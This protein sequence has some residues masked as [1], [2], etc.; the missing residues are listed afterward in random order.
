MPMTNAA[1]T[2]VDRRE[3]VAGLIRAIT[4]PDQ[5][6]GVRIPTYPSLLTTG[7]TQYRGF[8]EW[9][10]QLPGNVFWGLMLR[11][12]MFPLWLSQSFP[13]NAGTIPW[14]YT[15]VWGVDG[16]VPAVSNL[17]V[18]V[19]ASVFGLENTYAGNVA[20]TNTF[21]GIAGTSIPS[22]LS[23]NL[24]IAPLA[25][26]RD[27]DKD[28]SPFI[29]VPAGAQ[30]T[31]IVF[32][33]NTVSG[34][35]TMG[36]VVVEAEYAERLQD[37]EDLVWSGW[38]WT[39]TKN[40]A[41][42]HQ[43]VAQ[44]YWIRPKNVSFSSDLMTTGGGQ[45]HIAV[46]VTNASANPTVTGANG[47]FGPNVVYN[48][49]PLAGP[50]LLPAPGCTG[51]PIYSF[52]QSAFGQH[53]VTG[54]RL[55]VENVTAIMNKEGTIYA[56]FTDG[57]AKNSFLSASSSSTT[58]NAI[59]LLA[60][61]RKFRIAAEHGFTAFV[62]PGRSL[63]HYRNGMEH[64]L[65]VGRTPMMSFSDGDYSVLFTILDPDTSTVASKSAFS[66]TLDVSWE[67]TTD[68]QFVA[69]RLSG[70]KVETLHEAMVQIMSRSP[71]Q[72]YEKG[73][74]LQTTRVTSKRGQKKAKKEQK[75]KKQQPNQQ[76]QPKK[77]KPAPKPAAAGS[78]AA[79]K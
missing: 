3:S 4:R 63:E 6:N 46:I 19:N 53:M 51:E 68:S 35:S 55:A 40:S 60:P 76:A 24:R 52:T 22:F 49:I 34:T 33:N 1:R 61:S 44:N 13:T 48:S 15:A 62:P 10:A 36:D 58:L 71:F 56:G 67:Y 72:G 69:P 65:Q 7:T 50:F 54:V 43:T 75:P 2:G 30:I 25:R 28:N 47:T 23:N 31:Q 79:K 12:P 41:Y 66:L 45:I 77:P 39:A 59:S 27:V 21:P 37:T 32:F 16:P 11:D 74:T 9:Q 42:R 8:N 17:D 78:K 29:F 26:I 20:Q 38:T 70:S 57:V 5:V 14:Q 64:Y 18:D 73:T